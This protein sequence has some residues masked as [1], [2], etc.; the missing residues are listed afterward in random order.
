MDR[1]YDMRDRNYDMREREEY[2]HGGRDYHYDEPYERRDRK[3]VV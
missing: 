1:E 3:S 2:T